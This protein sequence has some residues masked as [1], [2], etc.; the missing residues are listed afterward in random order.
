MVT[1][2]KLKGAA[3]FAPHDWLRH[4]EKEVGTNAR[5]Y[6]ALV[7]REDAAPVSHWAQDT[8]YPLYRLYFDTAVDASL[9]IKEL[10]SVSW[11][12]VQWTLKELGELIAKNLPLARIKTHIYPFTPDQRGHGAFTLLDEHTILASPTCSSPFPG[13]Q[14]RFHENRSDPP[15]TAYLK[16]Q[17]A[18]VRLGWFPQFEH[19]CLDAGACPGGWTWVLRRNNASVLAVDRSPLDPRLNSER[20]EFR[21]GNAFSI[22]P[23]TAGSFDLVCSDVI[24]YPQTLWEWVE[25]WLNS[26]QAKR[27]VVSI[28]M[29]GTPDVDAI[30]RF[31]SV[32]DSLLYHG[33]YNKHELTWIWPV[34]KKKKNIGNT[35]RV[36]I[37]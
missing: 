34:P 27:M 1:M 8:W 33:S 30:S 6:G 12:P 28:K 5:R 14:L 15:S 3:Y 13:G 22:L 11:F 17:E 31:A 25:Q 37:S 35:S 16:L 20:L 19:R 4:V 26:N 21:K 2:E 9:Q 32:P 29:Q 10:G 7:V 24:C 36:E 23:T 18:L